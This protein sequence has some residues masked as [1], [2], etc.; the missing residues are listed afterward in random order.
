MNAIS[1]AHPTLPIPSYARVTNLH[2][3][4]SLIV[5]VNDR[6]P[7]HG[8]RIIDLS[9]KAAE[10]LQVRRAGTGRVR[11]EYA[12]PASLDG[13]DDR[14]LLATLRDGRPAPAHSV[15]QVAAVR[16]ALPPVHRSTAQES[17]PVRA[18]AA[19]DGRRA[20]VERTTLPPVRRV[21][22]VSA[23]GQP[24]AAAFAPT[25]TTITGRGLY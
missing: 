14:R 12:G 8:N 1:A 10:L 5:R 22:E 18:A 24:A 6:G 2:T 19:P 4:R 9:S 15:V 20:A 13:S 25:P 16:P 3:G 17:E 11:V 21:S 23:N 7:Y